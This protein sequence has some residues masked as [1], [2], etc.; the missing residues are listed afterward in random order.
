MNPA[1][2]CAI[3]FGCMTALILLGVPLAI[4][5]LTC[6]FIGFAW[7]S[8]FGLATTQLTNALFSLSHSYGFAV[9]PLFMA[10]GTL[11]SVTGMAEGT[12]QA[13]KK[14]VGGVR[15]GLLHSVVLANMVFGACSGMSVAGNIVFSRIALPELRKA[16]YDETLSIGTITSAGSL[17]VLIPPSVPII[18]FCLLAGV[19]I[20][21][22]LMT[23]ISAGI[24]FAVL[25]ML[26]IVVIGLV[27]PKKIPP[28]SSE[29]VSVWEKVKTLRL[30]LPI[31]VLFALIVGGSFAGWFPSTVGGAVAVVAILVYAVAKRTRPKIVWRGLI[32]GVLSF[33][34][35]YL[36]IIAGQ[37]FS[38][39]VTV[40]GMADA[41][42]DYIASVQMAPFG[43]FMLVFVFY[44]FCGC[45]MDA[46]SI[47]IIT[48]PVVFPVLTGVGY[49]ELVL[50][51]L[52]V[53][54]MEIASLTPPVGVGVFFVAQVTKMPVSRVFRGVAPFFV[55][56]AF[57][58]MIIAL[59]PDLILW[60]PRL[61]GL[62]A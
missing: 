50:V 6:S 32:E 10:L 45:F 5:M 44:L 22:A 62:T 9:I 46:L 23:G 54:S 11:A 2:I 49:H 58:V 20:G 60:L 39:F 42:S 4:S 3:M 38:R 48:V 15:G 14:W 35:V 40:T 51:M 56:D 43:V 26:L 41:I 61:L 34:G 18:A 36:I 55:L 30:L 21:Q 59:F 27:Q 31:A 47:I 13:A 1:I 8:G 29:R 12:F 37:F 52:L 7:V 24:L 16:N 28:R 25:T 33:A 17:S 19:S 57:M 53:F